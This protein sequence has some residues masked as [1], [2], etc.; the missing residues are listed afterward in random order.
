[1]ENKN[2]VL[3]LCLGNPFYGNFAVQ[4]ARSI[5]AV[6]PEM[7]VSCAYAGNV[8]SHNSNLPFDS[9][10]EVPKEYFITDG[11]PDYIKSKTYLYELS[12][13]DNTIFIDA[14]VI[15][16]PQKPITNLFN[17]LKECDITF[18]NRGKQK[19][20]EAKSGFIH[21]ADPKDIANAYG[22][23]GWLYN[24]ASEFIYWRRNKK[25][26]KFF[27][28]AQEVYVDPKIQFKK[29]A[30]HLPDELAF[31]IAMIKTGLYPHAEN[32]IPFYWEQ[33]ERK[34]MPVHEMYQKYYG[35][36]MGGNVNTQSQE[37]IYNNLANHY[38][39]K[40]GVSGY[41]PAKSKNAWLNERQQL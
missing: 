24:L 11:L 20:S 14:D 15:W 21:W 6:D 33:F 36:S 27:K 2:G 35:Y 3:L 19:V 5:K 32:F 8:L 38:N 39:A 13:Y 37:Q 9:L 10:I 41:F 28:V 16:L 1:M 7:K 18:S 25:V 17:E 34:A 12:P 40:C 29:F 23:D 30:H 26:E 22:Q 31:E 4:L